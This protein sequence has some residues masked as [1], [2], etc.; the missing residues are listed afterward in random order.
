MI[1]TLLKSL[2]N[3]TKQK[4]AV[5][6]II[7]Y[8]ISI[9]TFGLIDGNVDLWKALIPVIGIHFPI[10][11]YNRFVEEIVIDD[12]QYRPSHILVAM[13]VPV[14]ICLLINLFIWI[15]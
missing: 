5:G 1:K 9:I 10:F 13:M 2:T 15:F 14:I 11:F 4:I 12:E 7:F 6:S 8:I 3:K